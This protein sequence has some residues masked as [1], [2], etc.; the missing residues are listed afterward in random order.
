MAR[1]TGE[2]PKINVSAVVRPCFTCEVG[3]YTLSLHYIR[4]VFRWR[5]PLRYVTTPTASQLTG[6]STG[7]LREWTS[8]RALIPADVPPKQKGSPAKFSWQTILIL[9]IAVVLRERFN[10]ELQANKASFA[11]LRQLLDDRS[12]IELWGCCL[13][14]KPNDWRIAQEGAP[15]PSGDIL[16][17]RMNPHL[18]VLRD[19]FTLPEEEA[20]GAQLDLWSLPNI[21][22]SGH[23][24][25]KGEPVSAT[26][27]RL[28]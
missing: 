22:F 14:L 11:Q 25:P 28:A 21:R 20:A 2:Q 5:F 9:R 16:L 15:L 8:R 17:I 7:Q 6:L 19:G 18:E 4:L 23:A 26:L 13:V 3:C 10:L 12:F 24:E 27:R 1:I